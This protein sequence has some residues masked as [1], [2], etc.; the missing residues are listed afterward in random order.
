[1]IPR[2]QYELIVRETHCCQYTIVGS[3][4][5]TVSFKKV[6]EHPITVRT[7][8]RAGE[9]DYFVCPASL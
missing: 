2:Q 9:G 6:V 4:G 7:P 3:R 1:M 8:G 5:A